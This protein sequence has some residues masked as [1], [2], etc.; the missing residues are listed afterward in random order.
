M[1][2]GMDCDLQ[3]RSFLKEIEIGSGNEERSKSFL[4]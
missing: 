1:A 3:T 2:F 4:D